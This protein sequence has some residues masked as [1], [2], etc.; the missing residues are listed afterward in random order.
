MKNIERATYPKVDT[1]AAKQEKINNTSKKGWLGGKVLPWEKTPAR[2]G[3]RP[4]PSPQQRELELLVTRMGEQMKKIY[5]NKDLTWEEKHDEEE[6]LS[7]AYLKAR[8]KI[9]GLGTVGL[10]KPKPPMATAENKPDVKAHTQ[11]QSGPKI[12]DTTFNKPAVSQDASSLK[13]KI[14]NTLKKLFGAGGR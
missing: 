5:E 13:N 3:D 2:S 11:P 7:Q 14:S 12:I 1:A 6:R 4:K 9:T 10:S 8:D